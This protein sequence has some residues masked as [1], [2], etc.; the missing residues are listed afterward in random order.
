MKAGKA[1]V[2]L[3]CTLIFGITALS[4]F[5]EKRT[6]SETENRMLAER[7]KAEPGKVLDG[8]FGEDYETYLLDQFPFRDRWIRLKNTTELVLQKKDMGGVWIGKDGYLMEQHTKDSID[9]GKAERNGARAAAFVNAYGKLLGR[10]HVSMLLAPTADLILR[11]QLP[12]YAE[13]YDGDAYL[14]AVKAQVTEGTFVDVRELLSE[15]RDESI[16]Y[17]TDHHWNGLGAY[18]AYTVWAEQMGLTPMK[19]EEFQV[20]TVSE[21]FYGTTQGKVQ[22]PVKPDAIEIYEPLSPVSYEVTYDGGAEVQQGLYDYGKLKTRDKYA[23]Y[24]G[25]NH[26]LTEI[27]SSRKN[28]RHLLV[29]K[30]SYAHVFVPFAANHFER[31]TMVDFRYYRGNLQALL[32]EEEVTDLLVLYNVIQ[33]AEDSNTLSFVRAMPDG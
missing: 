17:R 13:I 24:L 3:F 8:S 23:V 21:D 22:L 20:R 7:P 30:D 12:E 4:L 25:G 32:E 33:L 2:L 28:G 31:V 5:S 29:V 6:Y 15:H 14:E 9:A 26:G 11:E 18:Y 16:Y 27:R 19:R 1:T 10:E